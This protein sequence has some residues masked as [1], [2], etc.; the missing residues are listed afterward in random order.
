LIYQ[1]FF[2]EFLGGQPFAVTAFDP[3]ADVLLVDE[4]PAKELGHHD[5][6]FGL[7]IEPTDELDG[8][9]AVV[10]GEVE[11]FTGIGGQAGNFSSAH[12]VNE[13]DCFRL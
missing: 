2:D 4:P 9:N 3:F 5:L 8:G 13:L 12:R 7:I 6:D 11:L 10:K 1:G